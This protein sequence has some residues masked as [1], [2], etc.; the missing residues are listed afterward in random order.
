MRVGKVPVLAAIAAFVVVFGTIAAASNNWYEFSDFF[1]LYHGARSLVLGHDPYDASWWLQATGGL[2]P[3]PSGGLARTSCYGGP[4]YPLW[5]FLAM[6]PIGALPLEPAAIVWE[7]LSIGAALA[8]AWWAWRAVQGPA[9][10]ALLYL[11]LLLASQ[12]FWLLVIYGQITGVMLAIAGLLALLLTRARER[13]AGVALATLALKPQC[14]FLTLPAFAL[15]GLVERR[16]RL[17]M[18]AAL[19]AVAMTVAPM[20]F[21]PAWPLEWWVEVSARRMQVVSLLPTA[22]GFAGDVLA[23]ASIGAVL[24]AAV[25]AATWILLRGRRVDD[26]GLLA[27]TLPLSLFATTYAWTY[28]HLV[29]FVSYAFVLSRA[30]STAGVRLPL[31][32]GTVA[33]AGPVP[34]VLYAIALTRLN[35]SLSAWIAAATALLVVFALRAGAPSMTSRSSV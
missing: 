34:W 33:L 16:W 26:V 4:G 35:E 5:T 7:S 29:L 22:W 28:D 9:R 19:A 30:S 32:L 31:V 15:R 27:L 11:A 18:A 12:P 14:V 21:V 24:I 23:N 6:L 17:L 13:A 1:C 2:R 25:L 10:F 20:I 8:G 3:T